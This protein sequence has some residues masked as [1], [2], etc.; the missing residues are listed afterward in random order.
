MGKMQTPRAMLGNITGGVGNPCTRRW[1]IQHAALGNSAFCV[2]FFPTFRS[3]QKLT[4]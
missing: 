1:E 3:V 4:E 2:H